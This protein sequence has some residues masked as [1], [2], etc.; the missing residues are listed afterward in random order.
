[1]VVLPYVSERLQRVHMK[2]NTTTAHKPHS[3]L[4]KHLV[5]PKEKNKPS[6]T[7]A[8]CVYEIS[9]KICEITYVGETGRLLG[10]RLKEHRKHAEKISNKIQKGLP[11]S[12]PCPNHISHQISDQPR[13]FYKSHHRL[14]GA[15]IMH[16]EDQRYQKL[17]RESIWI[18]RRGAKA[19]NNKGVPHIRKV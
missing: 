18:G 4:R 2:H 10:A 9:C 16:H 15:K 8:V 7:A 11:H 1:M 6:E 12:H 14:W 19:V 17:I 5:H 13:S 3:T